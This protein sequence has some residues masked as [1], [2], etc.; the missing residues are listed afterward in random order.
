M[1]TQ[2]TVPVRHRLFRARKIW[3]WIIG[4]VLCAVVTGTIGGNLTLI[5]AFVAT[6]T[7]TPTATATDTPTA[8]P[9]SSPTATATR[10]PLPS[11]TATLEDILTAKATS[12]PTFTLTTTASPTNT[13]E[14]TATAL[15]TEPLS[16][17]E[18]SRLLQFKN[19]NC[20]RKP[21]Y[22]QMRVRFIDAENAE[23]VANT[24]AIQVRNANGVAQY[25][26]STVSGEDDHGWIMGTVWT[27]HVKVYKKEIA[28]VAE[29]SAFNDPNGKPM[30]EF[31]QIIGVDYYVHIQ[32]LPTT[33]PTA[34]EE[35]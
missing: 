6:H 11:A 17:E 19:E 35:L 27:F 3:P 10:T 1:F 23:I 21:A 29:R 8:R 25:E 2:K 4:F 16:A 33:I 18:S 9:T 15:I 24:C 13:L 7:A 34:T 14:P 12:S 32:V 31:G 30:V 26:L 28:I 22:L 5:R 20:P